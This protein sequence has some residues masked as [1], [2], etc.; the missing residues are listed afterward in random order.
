M[1]FPIGRVAQLTLIAVAA[2]VA[3][4]P[5][6]AATVERVY[7]RGL[8]PL[9]QSSVTPLSNRVSFALDRK[10]TRLNSSHT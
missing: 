1:R 4:M 9:I 6:G 10:S 5:P 7:A 3:L 2:L 8:Y